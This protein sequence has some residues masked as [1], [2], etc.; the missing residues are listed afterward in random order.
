VSPARPLF[1]FAQL[2]YPWPLGPPDGRYLLRRPGEAAPAEPVHVLVLATLGAPQRHTLTRR[3]SRRRADPEPSP[4][5]VPT[6]RA[7]VVEVA[8]PLDDAPAAARWL[9]GAGEDEL[10][11]SVAAL[12]RVLHAF[13]LVSAD[14]YQRPVTRRQAL[15][16]RLGYGH[17]EQVADGE[18]TEARELALRERRQRRARVLQPQAR[19]A[20]TLAGRESLLVCEELALRTRFDLDQGRDREAALQLL[21]ALDAAIAELQTDAAADTLAPRLEQLR[22]QR[23]ATAHA[24]QSA[25]AG[26]LT[27]AE[28]ETVHTTLARIEAALRA[29]AAASA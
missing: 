10:E 6:G 11:A 19:L 18:W 20:A 2:E 3:R 24:A 17:G 15:V 9:A 1:R 13:R 8:A 4:A 26:P 12:N 27:P 28:R 25:L 23:Q 22:G 14:P 16:A 21:V 5:P 29:R 7:T